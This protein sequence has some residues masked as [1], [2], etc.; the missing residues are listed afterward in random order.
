MRKLSSDV[1]VTFVVMIMLTATAFSQSIVDWVK[2][3]VE[4][5]PDASFDGDFKIYANQ[6]DGY[7]HEKYSC[8]QNMNADL[9]F[10][11]VND[12]FFWMFRPELKAGLGDSQS[13]M[14]LHPYDVS[15]GLIPTF[16]YRFEQF[17]VSNGLDHR[18]F[19]VIDRSPSKPIVYW[20]KFILGIN[21]THRR[22][23]PMVSEYIG[24]KWGLYDRFIWQFTG[25]YYISDF[26]GLVGP[27]KLMS[28]V[29][30][31]YQYEF[32]AAV[33]CGIIAWNRGA[34]TIT[35]AS[36][37][38]FK[39]SAAAYWAQEIGT[40]A[41]FACRNFDTALFLRY[42]VDGGRFDDF[43]SK[44]RLFEFGFRVVK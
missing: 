17:H 31:H 1:A 22:M 26:F 36:M 4:V 18:C 28:I 9:T 11:S 13:G 2:E 38:G 24:K 8:E 14:V 43:D 40:E 30:P 34:L 32:N 3:S 23:H 7:F 33:S 25:A 21:S 6:K 15:F 10:V 16:E 42:T 35:N 19:H 5:M 44:D 29:R 41:L 39:R 37:L 27:R 20:N 12:K